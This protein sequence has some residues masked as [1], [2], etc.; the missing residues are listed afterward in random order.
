MT[1]QKMTR[2]RICGRLLLVFALTGTASF[3][4]TPRSSHA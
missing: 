2:L 4:V 3:A 1:M